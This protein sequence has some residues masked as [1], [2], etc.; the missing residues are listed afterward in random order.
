MCGRVIEKGMAWLGK[1][2]DADGYVGY[3]RPGDFPYGSETLT[4]AGALCFLTDKGRSASSSRLAQVVRALKNTARRKTDVDYYRL[5]FVTHALRAA[6][7]DDPELIAGLCS[8]L[9]ACQEQT[10][11][12]AGS[13]EAKDR[14][15]SAGGRVYA[16]AMAVLAL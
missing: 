10:G 15:S 4:A 3:S 9:V 5:Y 1:V 7:N 14:W 2:V 8:A 16:T 13:F 11:V 12:H 6:G